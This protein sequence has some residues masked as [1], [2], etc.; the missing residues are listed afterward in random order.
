MLWFLVG[1]FGALIGRNEAEME[2]LGCPHCGRKMRIERKVYRGSKEH[3]DLMRARFMPGIPKFDS[4]GFD[5]HRWKYA[6]SSFD[7]K[8]DF[9]LIYRFEDAP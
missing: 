3:S 4:F 6:H 2:E 1:L 7:D 5:G 8:G 9:D